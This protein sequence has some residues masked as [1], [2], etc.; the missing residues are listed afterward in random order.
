MYKNIL[1]N[2]ILPDQTILKLSKNKIYD[3]CI[4]LLINKYQNYKF[5]P[6]S[7]E[8]I[9]NFRRNS[10]SKNFLDAILRRTDINKELTIFLCGLRI[11]TLYDTINIYI[12]SYKGIVDQRMLYSAIKSPL[13]KNVVY[14]LFKKGYQIDSHCLVIACHA[15][16]MD[17]IKFVLDYKILPQR[18]HFNALL[19][20]KY[21]FKNKYRLLAEY[22]YRA[23]REDVINAIKNGLYIPD[24]E[25]IGVTADKE[26]LDFCCV[27]NVVPDYRFDCIS[28]EMFKL[29]GMCRGVAYR[30]TEKYIKRHKLKP[31]NI[32]MENCAKTRSNIRLLMVLLKEGG[33]VN[34]Q[35]IINNA[36]TLCRNKTLMKLIKE[37]K[38]IDDSKNKKIKDLETRVKKLEHHIQDMTEK[39]LY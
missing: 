1:K 21:G 13:Q 12:D 26:I 20:N 7:V 4:F 16:S 23:N 15:G 28:Q 19:K 25:K 5:S 18:D 36:K 8:E 35:C 22:G 30:S 2:Q 11:D 31:D 24:I 27:Y 17:D 3:E 14:T 9:L 32:C 38:K 37:Y 6:K 33:K 39:Y 10:I 29:Y 34:L